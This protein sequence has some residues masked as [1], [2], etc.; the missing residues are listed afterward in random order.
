MSHGDLALFAHVAT[1]AEWEIDLAQ[2]ALV[3]AEPDYPGLD[4]PRYL[5]QLDD[6][7][8]LICQRLDEPRPPG[9]S[10]LV[11]AARVLHQ[12]L[13]FRGNAEDYYD[14]RNSYLNEVLDRKVGIPITLALVLGECARRAGIPSQG[15]SFPGHFLQ[16]GA[17]ANGPEFIDPFDGRPLDRDGLRKLHARIA[18]GDERDPDPRLLEPASKKQILVRMLNNLRGIWSVRGDRERLRG[19][20]ERLQLLQPTDE[21]AAELGK[22]PSPMRPRIMN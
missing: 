13:G 21:Q 7:G 10:P 9:E 2:S 1:R 17:G 4:I 19:V 3:I 22:M 11:R 18:G 14:P 16:R 12:E 8:T 15:V 6:I 5:D 20:L